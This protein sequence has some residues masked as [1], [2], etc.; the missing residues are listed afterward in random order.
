MYSTLKQFGLPAV[1]GSLAVLVSHPLELTKVRL[2]LDNELKAR[3][4]VGEYK[5]WL[6]CVATSWRRGGFRNLWRGVQFGVAREF[7]FNAARIGSFDFLK[8]GLGD[9]ML[10]GFC[11]GALG[12]FIA[13]PLEVLKVRAQALGGLTGHQHAN[14]GGVSFSEALR[15][16][17]RAEGAWR[18]A[19]NGLGASTL[20]GMLGPGTQLPAY[21]ELKRR[22]AEAGLD[23]ASPAVHGACSAASAGAS[24]LACNPMDVVRT[25]LYNQPV[26]ERRYRHAGDAVKKILAT[27]GVSGFYKGALSHYLRLGPHLVMVFIILERLRL[28]VPS[29]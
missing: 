9:P 20:R 22:C 6:D 17:V 4:S 7:F 28:V 18:V 5:G 12:G 19:T 24:I 29:S 15:N 11:S 3:G 8:V 10:A 1:A 26:G 2:Q 27:E 13:N 21:Y 16:A 14:I 25:R 23:I